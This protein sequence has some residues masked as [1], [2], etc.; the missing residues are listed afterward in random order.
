MGETFL[1]FTRVAGGACGMVWG[2]WHVPC[3][4]RW[5]VACGASL[6]GKGVI[7]GVR[8]WEVCLCVGNIGVM[9][10]NR[11]SIGVNSYNL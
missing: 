7:M 10:V 2:V 11:C 4:Y 3:G 6:C 8:V 5:R 9:G 1:F